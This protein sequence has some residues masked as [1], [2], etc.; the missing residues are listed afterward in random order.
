MADDYINVFFYTR[1]QET[2]YDP[3][4]YQQLVDGLVALHFYIAL[5]G[6]QIDQKALTTPGTSSGIQKAIQDAL[7]TTP[8]PWILQAY[9]LDPGEPYGGFTFRVVSDIVDEETDTVYGGIDLEFLFRLFD[10]SNNQ[11]AMYEHFLDALRLIYEIYHPVYGYQ[12]DP[13]I[14][15][16]TTLEEALA[17]QIHNLYSINFFGPEV[18]DKFGRKQLEAA[19]AE[20]ILPLVDGGILLLPRVLFSADLHPKRFQDVANALGLFAPPDYK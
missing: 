14:D 2:I 12:F 5:P 1:Q 9:S 20:R 18:V 8:A 3:G 17:L 13:R 7:G 10:E 4:N 19:P 6:E 16:F 11:S 15:D